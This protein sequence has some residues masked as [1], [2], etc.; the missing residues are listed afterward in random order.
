MSIIDNNTWLLI[1][2]ILRLRTNT[3]ISLTPT[4]LSGHQLKN[5]CNKESKGIC[6]QLESGSERIF[7]KIKFLSYQ[8]I[9]LVLNKKKLLIKFMFFLEKRFLNSDKTI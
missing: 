4:K 3:L 9:D 2:L 5:N 8:N 7:L 6:D 1:F